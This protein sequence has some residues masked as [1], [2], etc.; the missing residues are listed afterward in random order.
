[1][2]DTPDRL[3]R[4]SDQTSKQ[5]VPRSLVRVDDLGLRFEAGVDAE[6]LT[7]LS[8]G[9]ERVVAE[10]VIEDDVET[11]GTE[12]IEIPPNLLGV[13]DRGTVG[14]RREADRRAGTLPFRVERKR[15]LEVLDRLEADINEL[16]VA[17]TT[18]SAGDP[19]ASRRFSPSVRSSRSQRRQRTNTGARPKPRRG[20]GNPR[21][22]RR[23]AGTARGRA[24][25]GRS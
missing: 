13:P 15:G 2:Q 10:A 7:G 24:G 17:A 3:R 1:M 11:A 23:T 6:E 22:R 18:A 21:A 5:R 19:S 16:G 25:A 20:C 12:D 14:G 9:A 4:A 8:I